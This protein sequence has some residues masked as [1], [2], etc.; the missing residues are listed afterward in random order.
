V[1]A[2]EEVMWWCGVDAFVVNDDGDDDEKARAKAKDC[3]MGDRIEPI[4]KSAIQQQNFGCR[5][6]KPMERWREVAAAVSIARALAI[7][8]MVCSSKNFKHT[9]SVHT[10]SGW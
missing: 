9:V 6:Q 8:L 5:W 7:V 4:K 3:A 2:S 1:A 10:R